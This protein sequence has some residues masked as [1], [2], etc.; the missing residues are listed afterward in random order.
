MEGGRV[1]NSSVDQRS[2]E[3]GVVVE[4]CLMVEGGGVT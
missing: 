3:R 1:M 2:L 4:G